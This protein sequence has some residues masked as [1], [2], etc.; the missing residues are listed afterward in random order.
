MSMNSL[1]LIISDY[2]MIN[3]LDSSKIFNFEKY[4]ALELKKTVFGLS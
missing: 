4:I 3:K 1:A 2:R